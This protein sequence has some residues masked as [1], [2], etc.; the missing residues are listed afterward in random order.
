MDI[1]YQTSIQLPSNKKFGY[2]VSSVAL[3]LAI[4]FFWVSKFIFV[5]LFGVFAIFL[6]SLTLYA[7]HFLES[8]NASW[9]RFGIL[10]GKI[11]NPILLSIIFF[12]VITP[13]SLITRLFGRDALFLKKRLVSS[14]W[15]EKKNI[16][17]ESFRY[18]F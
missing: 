5:L 6:G 12:A 15:V 14:Y 10:L 11:V 13:V 4:Y 8:L 7:P 16:D 9:F 3:T 2:M 17:P 18:Q 1:N